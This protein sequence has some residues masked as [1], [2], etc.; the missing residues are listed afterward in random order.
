MATLK[1]QVEELKEQNAALE[2]MYKSDIAALTKQLEKER[3]KAARLEK[4]AD[5]A[6]QRQTAKAATKLRRHV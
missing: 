2:K 4:A 5:N 1:Q 3:A 6:K